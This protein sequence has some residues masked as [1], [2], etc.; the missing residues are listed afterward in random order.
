[1]C[2]LPI[3]AIS[4]KPTWIAFI[5]HCRQSEA[6]LY[7]LPIQGDANSTTTTGGCN[8]QGPEHSRPCCQAAL[9]CHIMTSTVLPPTAESQS[10][11]A[12]LDGNSA[13]PHMALVCTGGA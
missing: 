7:P 4:A 3:T 5:I 8:K 1:M 9:S 6:I 12:R 11:F 13:R 10:S 2:N